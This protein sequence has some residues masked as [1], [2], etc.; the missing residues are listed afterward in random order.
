MRRWH[1]FIPVL[2]AITLVIWSCAT[3]G[4]LPSG[5]SPAGPV[6]KR[7]L[8]NRELVVGTAGN[9]PPLNMTTIR[10]RVIGYEPDL[11]RRMA[12]AM[13]VK[14]RLEI[15]NF[16]ELLPAVKSGRI[17]MAMSGMTMTGRRNLE[18]AFVGPYFISGKSVLTK[19]KTVAGIKSPAEI[20]TPRTRL[21][22]LKDS[23][24]QLFVEKVLPRAKLVTT[25][26]YDEALQLVFDGK[27]DALIADYPI[28]AVAV[29]S[30]PDQGLTT[31]EQ[32]LTYE[33]VGIAMAA[34]DPHLVNWTHNFLITMQ[35]SGQLEK[36][37]KKWTQNAG[38]LPQL[39]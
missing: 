4:S 39:P 15:M 33:P 11:A 37:M 10:G 38:W 7:I 22:A 19:L 23:T 27:V 12:A 31:L 13:G 30:Y 14:L 25:N 9:M 24:S 32:P 34:N 21:A 3:T 20:D 1:S 2:I 35:G 36:L 5:S 6:V 17:D 28:C 18:F 16:N 29:L 26:T 8:A